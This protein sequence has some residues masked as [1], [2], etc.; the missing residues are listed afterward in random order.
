MSI[1]RKAQLCKTAI[2]QHTHVSGY[3]CELQPLFV[4]NEIRAW[5]ATNYVCAEKS[6]VFGIEAVFLHRL[7]IEVSVDKPVKYCSKGQNRVSKK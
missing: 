3:L 2:L 1:I 5:F 7:V 4:R 6:F